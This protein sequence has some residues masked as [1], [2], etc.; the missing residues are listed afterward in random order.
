[1]G[2]H[3]GPEDVAFRL[4]L[5][6]L[7]AN[8]GKLYM[9][10]FSADHISTVEAKE[11]IT[12]LQAELGGDEFSFYPGVSYRH[13]MV[14]K[15]GRDKLTFTPPHDIS[16]QTI[17][18]YMPQG[19]G[20]EILIDLMNSSQMLLNTHPVNDL[21]EKQR[22]LPA[23]SIWLWGHGRKPQMPTMQEKFN[24]S[25]G[26]VISAVDLIK[27]I[28]I[29]AGLDVIEVPGATGYLDT[30]Y[31]G[32]ADA[33]LDELS[34]KE[35]VYLHVEAPDE[36]GHNG[37]VEDKITAIESFDQDVVG[38][39]LEGIKKFD[40]W[41]VLVLPDHPTPVA[42]RTH[43]DKPVPFALIGSQDEFVGGRR[44]SAYSEEE[45]GRT[46]IVF[47]KGHLLMAKLLKKV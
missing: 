22:K 28:G 46:G 25:G 4:N 3:L 18:D 39:V 34:H 11:I 47:E 38:P 29:Y 35:F 5:V 17:D 24:I 42:L 37:S 20:A 6:T 33:A 41:R 45:A 13:L 32:K 15:G 9:D 12:T 40:D 30:N 21:R 26:S 16:G 27:G 31:R 7:T 36:A 43:T 14:W 44:A 1:M 10:D 8:Y 2:V 23:N 19:D